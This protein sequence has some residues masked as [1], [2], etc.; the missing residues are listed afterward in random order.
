MKIDGSINPDPE[1]VL[2]TNPAVGIAVPWGGGATEP[3][4]SALSLAMAS[5]R[6]VDTGT[7]VLPEDAGNSV[8]SAGALL[9]GARAAGRGADGA[10]GAS[11]PYAIVAPVLRPSMEPAPPAPAG[12]NAS[13]A[14]AS[15]V[16]GDV[17]PSINAT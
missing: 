1:G 10:M 15:A 6:L 5:T 7:C 2:L 16:F 8:S 12:I 17:L 3:P 4:D 9:C 14:S 11:M 13:R